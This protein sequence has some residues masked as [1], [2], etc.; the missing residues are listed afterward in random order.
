M[1]NLIAQ[2]WTSKDI[3]SK[4]NQ[5]RESVILVSGL[6]SGLGAPGGERR[7]SLMYHN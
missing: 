6:T 1:Q 5:R 7:S 4:S 3:S 2:E